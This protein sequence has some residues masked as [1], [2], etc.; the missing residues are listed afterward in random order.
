[1]SATGNFDPL[2]V[3]MLE[4]VKLYIKIVLKYR[5]D[6]THKKQVYFILFLQ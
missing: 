3:T 6:T 5:D 4:N 2:L 1:M